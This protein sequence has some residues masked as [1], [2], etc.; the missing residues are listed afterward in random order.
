MAALQ[1]W[2]LQA[3]HRCVCAAKPKPAAPKPSKGGK[4]SKPQPDGGKAKDKAAK[5]LREA[6][7]QRSAPPPPPAVAPVAVAHPAAEALAALPVL[8][9][10]PPLS[11]EQL[12]RFE[13]DGHVALRGLLSVRARGLDIAATLL[14][15][16]CARYSFCLRRSFIDEWTV[17]PR[18]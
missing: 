7:A 10:G 13:R 1:L 18:C 17:R 6:P 3:R 9:A 8:P 4:A 2:R 5:P 11:T 14:V 12:L 16:T 15:L